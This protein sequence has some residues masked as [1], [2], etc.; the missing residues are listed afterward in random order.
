[1]E[2]LRII[3]TADVHLGAPFVFLGAKG[4]DERQ[5]LREALE[6]VVAAA[7]EERCGAAIIAGDLFDSA[8]DVLESELSFAIRALG[9]AGSGCTVVILPG[10]HDFYAPG[11][12]YERERARFEAAGN[13]KILTPRRSVVEIPELSLAIHGKALTSSAG[14]EG[15]LSSLAPV[16]SCRWNVA[17]AHGSVEGFGGVPESSDLPLGLDALSPGFSYVA[18]GHWHSYRVV[19]ESLPTVIY[20]GSPELVARD[21]KGAG[22]AVLLALGADGARTSLVRTGKR[23]LAHVSVDC[24]GLEATEELVRKVSASVPEDQNLIL[25]LELTGVIKAEAA[26][27]PAEALDALGQRYFSARLAGHGPSRAISQEELLGVPDDTVAGKFVRFMLSRLEG[28]PE[29]KKGLY[30]EALQVGYQLFKGRNPLG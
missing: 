8:Y 15:P 20:S 30:E 3:H 1:M 26:V 29:D 24:T 10:S 5:A 9:C 4:A 7:R 27:D 23:R 22:T 13:V 2:E 19:R 28:A 11:S 12:V 25:D 14:V 6:R 21:Q 16:E 18:L 17:V